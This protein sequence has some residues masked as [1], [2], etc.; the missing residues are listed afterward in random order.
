MPTYI[1]YDKATGEI[2]FELL[3]ERRLRANPRVVK[4]KMSNYGVK[5]AGHRNHPQPTRISTEAVP[6]TS[7]WRSLSPARL[8]QAAFVAPSG[9]GRKR[10][11]TGRPVVFVTTNAA[12]PVRLESS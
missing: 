8:S 7:S 3:A 9:T 12:P 11:R 5:R 2:V 4:R 6:L 10:A 1:I